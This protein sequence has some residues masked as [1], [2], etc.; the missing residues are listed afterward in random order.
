MFCSVPVSSLINP[1]PA[2]QDFCRLLSLLLLFS[3][4]LYCKQYGPR[5]DCSFGS[6][7]IRVHYFC[8]HDKIEPE[9]SLNICS[10]RKKQMTF[11]GQNIGGKR[12]NFVHDTTRMEDFVFSAIFCQMSDIIVKQ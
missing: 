9:V 8:S 3:G 4:S 1:S 6:S 12:V 5:S 2:S 11:S 7:L 10:R